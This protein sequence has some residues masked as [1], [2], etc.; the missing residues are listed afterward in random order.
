MNYIII[1]TYTIL[2]REESEIHS[3]AANFYGILIYGIHYKV[4]LTEY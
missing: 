3:R 2:I 1:T 4:I